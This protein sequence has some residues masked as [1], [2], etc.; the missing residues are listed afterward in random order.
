MSQQMN[1]SA[2]SQTF[3]FTSLALN[4]GLFCLLGIAMSIAMS[5]AISSAS[6]ADAPPEDFWAKSGMTRDVLKDFVSDGGC[7]SSLRAFVACAEA[8]NSVLAVTEPGRRLVPTGLEKIKPFDGTFSDVKEIT[9]LPHLGKRATEFRMMKLVKWQLTSNKKM[10]R[11]EAQRWTKKNHQ[12]WTVVYNAA[13]AVLQE[14][15]VQLSFEALLDQF[16]VKASEKVSKAALYGKVANRFLYIYDSPHTSIEPQ[17]QHR[18]TLDNADA[19]F[20]GIGASVREFNKQFYLNP[21]DGGPADMVGIMPADRIVAVDGVLTTGLT[22]AE[23]VSKL[24]GKEKTTVNV[25][26]EREEKI[27]IEFQ[28]ERAAVL[29]KNVEYR[30]VET[31][32]RKM[33][34]ISVGTFMQEDLSDVVK[35]GAYELEQQG[36]KAIIL[37]LRENLGGILGEGIDTA[38]TFLPPGQ[39]VTQVIKDS[40][41]TGE[42]EEVATPYFSKPDYKSKLP[43]VLL[44]NDNSASASEV[45]GLALQENERAWLVGSQSYG[46][47]VGMSAMS[48]RKAPA[49]FIWMTNFKFMGPAKAWHHLY[50]IAPDFAADQKLDM[51]EDEKVGEHE[52]DSYYFEPADAKLREFKHTP[53]R[54]IKKSLIN[55]CLKKGNYAAKVSADFGAQNN[56]FEMDLQLLK[57]QEVLDCELSLK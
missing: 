3:L 25:A 56:P 53:A 24:R 21:I 44:M 29:T 9:P 48:L 35:Q 42:L 47:G 54:E 16:E 7:N 34:Y 14:N 36:A 50:G 33:G 2:K 39:M 38:A 52:G 4:A 11:A 22:Q 41:E 49:I 51:T 31:F 32:G 10:S 5:T 26:I 40:Y 15:K 17:E 55:E 27:Q 13:F 12:F 6:A 46:K 8:M 19:K 57:A 45:V 20:V 18:Q 1:R 30:M 23:L 28:I 37:D 43:M